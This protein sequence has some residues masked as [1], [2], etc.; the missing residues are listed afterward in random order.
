M[1]IKSETMKKRDV[2]VIAFALLM[3]GC[4]KPP[5]DEVDART[6]PIN[7]SS[8]DD[9]VTEAE[10][11]TSLAAKDLPLLGRYQTAKAYSDRA[12]LKLTY[13]LEDGRSEESLTKIETRY[14]GPNRINLSVSSEDNQVVITSDGKQI[15]TKIIDPIT[16]DFDGQIVVRD[17]PEKLLMSHLY[18]VTEL[19][20]PI[21][22]D[23]MLSALLGVPA[24]LDVLPLGI[25]LGEGKLIEL[26]SAASSHVSLGT[27]Q[28]PG[29]GLTCE[30][31]EAS[32]QEGA[33][34]FW[35]AD[36]TL[37]RIEFPPLTENQM[38][39]VR[40]MEL[41]VDLEEITFAAADSDFH[42]DDSGTKVRHFVL[43]PIPPA[44]DQLGEPLRRLSFL[45]R[46]GEE[47]AVENND[48]QVTILVWFHD[49][50]ASRMILESIEQVRTRNRSDRVRFAAVA[51][52]PSASA[53]MLKNWKVETAWLHDKSALGRDRMNIKQAPTTVVL[54]PKNTIQY[55]EVGANPNIGA[56]IAV[57]I[58]RLLAGQNVAASARSL[59]AEAKQSYDRLLSRAKLGDGWVEEGDLNVPAATSPE[60]LVL[61]ELWSNSEIKE[62]GNML[63]VPGKR[64][65][66]LVVDGW[67]KLALLGTDGKVERSIE[68]ELPPDEGISVLRAGSDGKDRALIACTSRGGKRA[69]VFD[70]AGKLLVQYPKSSNPQFAISDIAIHD[71]DQNDDPELIVGWQGSGGVHGVG[72]DGKRRWVN[73]AAPGVISIAAVKDGSSGSERRPILV[74]GETGL[75]FLV[76][77]EGKTLREVRLDQVVHKLVSWPGS[78]DGF[79][80]LLSPNGLAVDGATHIGVSTS[81]LGGRIFTGVDKDWKSV[82]THAMPGGVYRHQIDFPQSISLPEIGSTWVIPGSDGSIHFVSADGE[83]R[84]RF[85]VGKHLR[86]VAAVFVDGKPALVYT[87]DDGVKALKVEESEAPKQ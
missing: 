84:D 69:F 51:A 61:T 5:T 26:A 75:L 66:L 43:P 7:A 87:T 56:D 9:A 80:A 76:D 3:I 48:E 81:A 20:D 29:R 8:S 47:V 24:G 13:R 64:K 38:P 30:V 41:V 77:E 62:P 2:F 53:E 6:K 37:H 70:F 33:Y 16:N 27:K 36:D 52:E 54:G 58:E 68:L 17:A 25:L 82:W 14:A 60:K 57:V 22:P 71:I 85:F 78:A 12:T 18:E 21:S 74:A 40:Q 65:Q 19:I 31:I 35:V 83:F 39:G 46:G 1:L 11:R 34:R 32:A 49:H 15:T 59:F 42:V 44:T 28:I 45:N 67:N 63:V 23:E 73:Q 72:L 79:A 4:A 86:G 10:T 55:F 50:P